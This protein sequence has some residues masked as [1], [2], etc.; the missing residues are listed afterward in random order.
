LLPQTC[1]APFAGDA[2][3]RT[4][5][6]WSTHITPSILTDTVTGKGKGKGKGRMPDL[7]MKENDVSR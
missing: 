2:T 1:I 3:A 4:R 7:R 5:G 6:P